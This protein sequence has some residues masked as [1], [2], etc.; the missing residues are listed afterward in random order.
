MTPSADS[1]DAAEQN[2]FAT[3]RLLV[4]RAEGCSVE[5]TD[6]VLLTS[7]PGAPSYF[8][9]AFVKPPADPLRC[10]DEVRAFFV[11]RG[12]PFTLRCRSTAESEA[13]ARILGL[14]AADASPLMNASAEEIAPPTLPDIVR[15]DAGTW[16]DHIAAIAKGFGVPTDLAGRLFGPDIAIGDEYFAFNAYVDGE[17]ASTAAAVV[18]DGV[19]GIYNVAT[20]AAFRRRGLGE[21][22]T[23]AAIAE[24]CRR[25][26]AIATLQSSEMGYSIYERMGFRT[27]ATWRSFTSS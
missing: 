17:V 4:E 13:F 23:R 15:V 14:E 7:V 16:G 25:G 26:C 1:V 18:H 19:T 21:A 8:N 20:P 2:Y 9:S 5:E 27:V 22:T 3:W 12:T 10:V 11:E 6:D 24:G